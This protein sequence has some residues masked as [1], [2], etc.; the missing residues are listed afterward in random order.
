MAGYTGFSVGIIRN[1]V[2]WIP[3]NTL[4]EAGINRISVMERSWLRLMA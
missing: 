3:V 4:N 2:S 1:A